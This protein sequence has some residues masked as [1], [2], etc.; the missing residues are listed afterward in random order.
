LKELV[1]AGA[2]L[3]PITHHTMQS[4]FISLLKGLLSNNCRYGSQLIQVATQ[5]WLVDLKS[6]GVNLL[7]YGISEMKLLK[8]GILKRDVQ[9]GRWSANWS[10]RFH[11]CWRLINF[12]YGAN[13]E[14]WFIWG[15]EICDGL[16]GEFWKM[17]EKTE[18]KTERQPP[19]AWVE[20]SEDEDSDY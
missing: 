13:P 20:S 12:T 19:G 18:R 3:H 6:S 9:C 16:A 15:S 2:D 8:D 17:V 4:P 11:P 10:E 5:M 7:E 1:N 14:A